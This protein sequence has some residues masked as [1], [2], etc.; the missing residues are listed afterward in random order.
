LTAMRAETERLSSLVEMLLLS[1]S[2][3]SDEAP[4]ISLAVAAEQAH[5]H[6]VD[7][8]AS[9]NVALKLQT[10]DLSA[11]VSEQELGVVL[12]NLLVNA[13][14]A[15]PEGAS[16]LIAVAKQGPNAEI[17]VSD[18]GPGVPDELADKI[19]DRLVKGE[20]SRNRALGGFGIGLAVCKRIL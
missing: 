18:H 20:Q 15:S 17:S 9:K 8:F 5:A 3:A 12:N 4:V 11:K 2:S 16:C 10:E 6:W 14:A 13:L 19:F 1:A 7:Q